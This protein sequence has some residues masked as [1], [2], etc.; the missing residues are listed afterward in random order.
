MFR[1]GLR[2]VFVDGLGQCFGQ[3][4]INRPG[5]GMSKNPKKISKVKS[6]DPPSRTSSRKTP[7]VKSNPRSRKEKPR[8]PSIV[9]EKEDFQSEV[10]FQPRLGCRACLAGRKGEGGNDCW[11]CRITRLQ[12]IHE[13]KMKSLN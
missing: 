5:K 13:E 7:G 1:E 4:S 10:I 11:S 9:V 2:V 12:K 6:A 3:L 8:L